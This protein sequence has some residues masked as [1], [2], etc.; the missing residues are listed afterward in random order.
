MAKVK[1][2]TLFWDPSPSPDVIAYRVYHAQGQNAVVDYNSQFVQV[3]NTE[4]DLSLVLDEQGEGVFS[5]K[6]AAVD[7]VGNESDLFQSPSWVNVP[8]D[9]DPPAAVSGGGIR[10]S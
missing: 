7:D 6:V 8:L 10:E 5:F 1:V 2:K 4:A 3:T 9:V